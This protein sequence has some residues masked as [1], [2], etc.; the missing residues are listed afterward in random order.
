MIFELLRPF[1]LAIMSPVAGED[2][3][4]RVM[5]STRAHVAVRVHF[6]CQAFG[7]KGTAATSVIYR[8]F[9]ILVYCGFI[10]MYGYQ[11]SLIKWKSQFQSYVNLWPMILSIQNKHVIL[12]INWITKSTKI[13][14]QRIV[15][16][17]QYK[18]KILT[19][20]IWH[21]ALWVNDFA[22]FKCRAAP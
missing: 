10:N 13:S 14:I 11:S 9:V 15:M 12:W 21:K 1:T 16:K 5:F 2:F 3:R 19:K 18:E 8:R 4:F 17:P 22:L 7:W 20:Q 6:S